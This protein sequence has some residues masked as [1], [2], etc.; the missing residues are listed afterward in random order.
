V[1]VGACRKFAFRPI[2]GK[3]TWSN[4]DSNTNPLDEILLSPDD[5]FPAAIHLFSG[6]IVHMWGDCNDIFHHAVYPGSKTVLLSTEEERISLVLKRAIPRGSRKGHGL[7]GTGRRSS[8]KLETLSP[9]RPSQG[10]P[11]KKKRTKL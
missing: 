8:K 11:S 10:Q 5:T 3:N 7:P 6:D 2:P 4:C 9:A 1:S